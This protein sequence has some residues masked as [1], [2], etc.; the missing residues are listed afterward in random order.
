MQEIQKASTE[1]MERTIRDILDRYE[2]IPSESYLAL[3]G[4]FALNCPCNSHLVKKFGFKDLIAPPCANDSGI[5][6]G[7]GLYAFYKMMNGRKFSVE[8]EHA[9]YGEREAS[10][11]SISKGFDDYVACRAQAST[12]TIVDDIERGPIVWISGPAEM[13]PRALGAR[14][15]LADPRS[16]KSKE[17]LNRIKRREWWRPVAPIILP[18]E[19]HRIFEGYQDSPFMLRTFNVRPEYREALPAIVHFDG[20]ARVQSLSEGPEF[21]LSNSRGQR[22][23]RST[24]EL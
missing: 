15:I 20:S 4:G 11:I 12:E 23:Y 13:G 24:I 9:Y 17:V 2:I 14:S 6:L 3:S 19:G 16:A 21:G 10:F 5:A 22:T 7:I 18:N 8:I 1:M